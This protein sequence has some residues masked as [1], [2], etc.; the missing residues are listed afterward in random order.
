MRG[1]WFGLEF[2]VEGV[3]HL[4]D[5]MESED[6]DGSSGVRVKSDGSLRG[7]GV[8]LVSETPVK[9][10]NLRKHL[11]RIKGLMHAGDTA[12]VFSQ[13]CSTHVHINVQDLTPAQIVCFMLL[14]GAVEPLMQRHVHEFRRTNL[15]CV[16]VLM[17]SSVHTVLPAVVNGASHRL[18]HFGK[19][20]SVNPGRVRDL[21]SLEFRALHGTDDMDLVYNWCMCIQGL[22]ELAAKCRTV[23]DI[24]PV[25]D[26]SDKLREVVLS[27][28]M[29]D[30]PGAVYKTYTE[31]LLLA[32]AAATNIKAQRNNG[33]AIMYARHSGALPVAED[34]LEELPRTTH[35]SLGIWPQELVDNWTAGLDAVQVPGGVQYL[36][37]SPNDTIFVV[38]HSKSQNT[39]PVQ[40]ELRFRRE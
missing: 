6:N 14:A 16:P 18:S 38:Q 22:R 8:E 3:P 1:A 19:Y 4:V 13:R 33:P 36:V 35:I 31:T 12:P 20:T 30:F 7:Y 32:M 40:H 15:F 5:F 17:C 29:P 28:K 11:Q 39:R 24:F 34:V 21:G 23:E 10:Q 25:L 37:R 26:A 2:E 27:Y 9:E